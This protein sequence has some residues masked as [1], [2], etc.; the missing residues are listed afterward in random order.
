MN[1]QVVNNRGFR[2]ALISFIIA[3]LLA[4]LLLASFGSSWGIAYGQSAGPTVVENTNRQPTTAPSAVGDVNQ[5]PVGVV[6]GLPNT[7]TGNQ[8]AA[9]TADSGWKL[10][11][12]AL[13][14]A[15]MLVAGLVMRKYSKPA[16]SKSR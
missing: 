10:I 3:G 15:N 4:I 16:K 14:I 2:T 5:S 1:A 12:L 6:P 13:L 7:G 11:A 8:V 9:T